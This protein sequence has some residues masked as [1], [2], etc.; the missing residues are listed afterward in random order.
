MIEYM[1]SVMK[2]KGLKVP[3]DDVCLTPRAKHV[4]EYLLM[5]RWMEQ[6]LTYVK[7]YAEVAL[8]PEVTL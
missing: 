1:R 2:P 3:P 5:R 8:S 6:W 4:L 7:W